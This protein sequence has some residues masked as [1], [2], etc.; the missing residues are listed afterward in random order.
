VRSVDEQLA[1]LAGRQ[2]GVVST[3]QLHALG[4]GRNA[5]AH[6]VTTG[7][8]TRLHRGVFRVGPVHSPFADFMAATLACGPSGVLSH[9][10]AAALLGIRRPRSGPVDVTVSRGQARVRRGLVIHRTRTLRPDE[11]TTHHGI[12]TTTAARTLL[13]IATDLPRKH[14]TRAV[15]EAQIQGHLDHSSLADAVSRAR[16]HRGVAALRAA[17]P[18]EA[19]LT[20]S[21]AERRLIEL[22]RAAELPEPQTNAKVG[23]YEVDAV[24]P[25]ER[26]VVEVDGF[27]FHGGREAFERDRLR[28]AELVAAGWRVQRVTWRQIVDEPVALVARLARGLSAAPAPGRPHAAAAP[29]GSPPGPRRW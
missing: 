1:R 23:G 10:S 24:W 26:L 17:A 20:R 25:A 6:R 4:V 19:K 14:L 5:I 12:R 2:H 18:A 13:D 16:G 22:V 9:H 29:P 8:L 15:E 28:D 7:R 21:E 27:A 3:S 11:I